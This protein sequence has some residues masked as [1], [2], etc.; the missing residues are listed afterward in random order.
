MMNIGEMAVAL[1]D[2]RK[3]AA[4][5]K[6]ELKTCANELCLKCGGYH[7]EHLGAC[8]GCRWKDVRHDA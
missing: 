2:A 8:D 5:L 4:R 7:E 6:Q 3:E 1:G